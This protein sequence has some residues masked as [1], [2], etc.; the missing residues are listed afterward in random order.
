MQKISALYNAVVLSSIVASF[1]IGCSSSSGGSKASSANASVATV[2]NDIGSVFVHA[3]ISGLCA[4]G[5]LIDSSL[6]VHS[7]IAYLTRDNCADIPAA[8]QQQVLMQTDPLNSSYVV[9][10]TLTYADSLISFNQ[11]VIDAAG[12]IYSLGLQTAPATLV[13]YRVIT[14]F[15]SQGSLVWSK[16]LPT[17]L[18]SDLASLRITNSGNLV[19]SGKTYQQSSHAAL[20]AVLDPQ[21]AI[22]TT[23][24]FAPAASQTANFRDVEVDAN[25]NVYAVAEIRHASDNNIDC[26]VIKVN[27]SGQILWQRALTNLNAWISQVRLSTDETELYVSGHFDTSSYLGGIAKFTSD[28][29]IE[30]SS[31]LPGTVYTIENSFDGGLMLAG[32]IQANNESFIAKLA[33][34]GVV[35]WSTSLRSSDESLGYVRGVTQRTDGSFIV[36]GLAIRGSGG[37]VGT[38]TSLTS[39]GALDWSFDVSRTGADAFQDG[40][41]NLLDGKIWMSLRSTIPSHGMVG[42]LFHFFDQAAQP[43]CTLCTVRSDIA[44][45]DA[46]LVLAAGSSFTTQSLLSPMSVALT[47]TDV[48]IKADV[49][50]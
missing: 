19:I 41:S 48:P 31:N 11:S 46:G 43:T 40:E 42:T 32:I 7:G 30:W 50:P 39:A 27:S 28:G 20:L 24:A 6:E 15:N 17:D 2:A 21:G 22:L 38:V 26:V 13:Q 18:S 3:K 44:A 23:A 33:G 36:N 9:Y 35:A 4:D 12:N 37:V 29:A 14:K 47:L 8:S 45:T 34:A 5:Q 49:R 10:N 16:R 25:G 1:N